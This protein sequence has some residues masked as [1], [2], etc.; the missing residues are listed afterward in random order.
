[1]L[2]G[3]GSNVAG[4]RCFS[5]CSVKVERKRSAKG[6]FGSVAVPVLGVQLVFHQLAVGASS[7]PR[8]EDFFVVKRSGKFLNSGA[9]RRWFST[10][11]FCSK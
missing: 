10:G 7:C 2:G 4:L 8:F 9:S 1:M 6:T 5:R 3:A 11:L